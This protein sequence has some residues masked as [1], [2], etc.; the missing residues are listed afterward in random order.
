M[1]AMQLG[2]KL[3][4]FSAQNQDNNT[5]NSQDLLGKPL[6]VY[7]YPRALT[8]GCTTQACD[9][10]DNMTLLQEYALTIVGI[11]PDKPAALK[12][13][14]QAKSLNF[15]LLSDP[16]KAIA[17]QFDAVGEKSMFGKKYVGVFRNSYLFDAAGSL[18]HM[19][20]HVKPSDHVALITQAMAGN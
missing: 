13:F 20:P 14:E 7:F 10:R 15:I 4:V 12:K 3:P 2:S 8:P 5:V 17:Q 18:T 11:S 6:L 19:W 16:D 9:L 1:I